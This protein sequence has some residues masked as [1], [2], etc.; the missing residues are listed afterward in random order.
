MA[1][2]ASWRCTCG[3]AGSITRPTP[4]E[5]VAAAEI[6]RRWHVRDDHQD[7]EARRPP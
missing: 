2:L 4:A 7:V 3:E 5:A 6:R 1:A